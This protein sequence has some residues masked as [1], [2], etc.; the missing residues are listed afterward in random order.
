MQVDCAETEAMLMARRS[1][2]GWYDGLSTAALFQAMY[3]TCEIIPVDFARK[4]MQS[5]LL[6]LFNESSKPASDQDREQIRST[7]KSVQPDL[8]S[9][10]IWRGFASPRVR[11]QI[12]ELLRDH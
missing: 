3:E 7:W 5:E 10:G 1:N 4:R 12:S 8:L 9:F 2:L 11:A 6:K